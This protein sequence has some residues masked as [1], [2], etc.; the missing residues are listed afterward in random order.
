VSPIGEETPLPQQLMV[1]SGNGQGFNSADLVLAQQS[2]WNEA[3]VGGTRTSW[4]FFHK[5]RL[6]STTAVSGSVGHVLS[7]VRLRAR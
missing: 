4:R 5:D 2:L 1:L 3:P 6:G 7:S